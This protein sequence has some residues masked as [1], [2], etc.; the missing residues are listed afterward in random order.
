L[1]FEKE[2]NLMQSP[3]PVSLQSRELALGEHAALRSEKATAIAYGRFYLGLLEKD[4]WGSQSELAAGLSVS[5]GH[6]SKAIKAARLPG[7][8][9]Q[10]F[11]AESRVSFRVVEALDELIKVVGIEKLREH[12]AQIGR[13][14]DVPVPQL[15]QALAVGER[16]DYDRMPFRLSVARNGRYIRID[17]P[18]IAALISRLPEVQTALDLAIRITAPSS[19]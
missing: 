13:R 3:D 19:L 17:S 16:P 14:P 2:E 11:G 7:P 1:S 6:V 4:V 12:A 9:V 10:A 18:E 15:L 8:V 5:K